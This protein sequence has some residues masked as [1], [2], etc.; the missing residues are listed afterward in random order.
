MS[1]KLEYLYF[2]EFSDSRFGQYADSRKNIINE[3]NYIHAW[4]K[5][6]RSCGRGMLSLVTALRIPNVVEHKQAVKLGTDL[7]YKLDDIITGRYTDLRGNKQVIPQLYRQLAI[8]D[9][10]HFVVVEFSNGAC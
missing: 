3:F 9:K 4:Y 8:F 1:A 7:H 6:E 5:I 10:E 2:L